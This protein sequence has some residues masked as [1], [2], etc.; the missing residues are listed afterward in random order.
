MFIDMQVLYIVGM[1]KYCRYEGYISRLKSDQLL[2]RSTI[3]PFTGLCT[4]WATTIGGGHE[5]ITHNSFHLMVFYS[6]PSGSTRM[7]PQLVHNR[8][9]GLHIPSIDLL[10]SRRIALG[11]MLEQ[12]IHGGLVV[13]DGGGD[14]V[15]GFFARG[16][17]GIGGGHLDEGWEDV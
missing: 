7:S 9:G 15:D 12:L 5:I 17:G 14:G 3:A 16:G 1:R 13:S 11:Q 6:I 4:A 10:V 2:K 8:I